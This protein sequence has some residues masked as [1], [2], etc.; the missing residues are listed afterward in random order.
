VRIAGLHID[1]FGIF[2][3]LDIAGFSPGL[4]VILGENES[5][6]TTL[7]AF[8]RTILF[9]FP[10]GQRRENIYP[11]LAGGRHGGHLTL[12]SG[13]GEEYVVSRYQGRNRGPV[14][15]TLPD[16]NQG[17]EEIVRQLTGAATEDLFRSIFAFSLEELERFDSLNKQAV[18]AAIYSAGAGVGKVSLAKVEKGLQDAIGKIFK[19]GGRNPIINILLRELQEIDLSIG[20]RVAEIE[21]Y[22]GLQAEIH[23]MATEVGSAKDSLDRKRRRLDRVR[24]LESGWEDWVSLCRIRE[25]IANLPK[26]EVFPTDGV[27]RLEKLQERERL[28][29]THRGEL[30]H[31]IEQVK[32][33]LHGFEERP[34]WLSVGEKIHL[35]ER[36]LERFSA[37]NVELTEIRPR[38]ENQRKALENDLKGLGPDWQMESLDQFDASVSARE[39][40]LRCQEALERTRDANREATRS[41]VRAT[42]SLEQAEVREREAEKAIGQIPEPKEKDPRVLLERRLGMRSLRNMIQAGRD[43]RRALEHLKER[44]DDLR[45]QKNGLSEQMEGIGTS[46]LWPVVVAVLL[47]AAPGAAAGWYRDLFAG[48]IV[49]AVGL[50]VS[51][52][53]LWFSLGQRKS[54]R[55]QKDLLKRQF[56]E[57]GEKLDSFGGEEARLLAEISANDQEIVRPAQ[58]FGLASQP[59]W[60]EVDQAEAVVET[61]QEALH[62]WQPTQQRYQECKEETERRQKELTEEEQRM[63]NTQKELQASEQHWQRWLSKAGLAES[64]SPNGALE[65]MERIRSLRQQAGS[66]RELE[67][68]LKVIEE[69]VQTYQ[70]EARSIAQ[71]LKVK[72]ARVQDVEPLVH[73][74]VVELKHEEKIQRSREDLQRQFAEYTAEREQN[75]VHL[76][77]VEKELNNLFREGG[78]TDEAEFRHRAHLYDRHTSEKEAL[79]QHLR[80][81]ENFGGRGE[82]QVR[83]QEQ[84]KRCSPERLQAERDELEQDVQ[85]LEKELASLQEQFG[86]LDERRQQLESA[87]ELSA[88]RQ[89]RNGLMAELKDAARRWSALTIC[90]GFFQKAR[91]IYEKERKQP[92]VRESEHFFRTI[93]DGR[94]QTIVAPHGEER[95]QIIGANGSRYD[96]D[97]LSR[98]TAEQLYLCLRFGYIE[99]FGR[100]ARPLP[101]V[102]DDILVNFDPQRARAA[103]RT[104]LGLAEKHQIIFFTCHPEAVSLIKELDQN[105]PVWQLEGG[106]CRL[107]DSHGETTS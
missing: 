25:E 37:A 3:E 83:F 103:I 43:L 90:L 7:L 76:R 34:E 2:H 74:M 24:L 54:L 61:E 56:F 107:D 104:M 12:L 94:Y 31:K 60:E 11:P 73:R 78:A 15:V 70:E 101:V 27:T 39:E 17:D 72:D 96:L 92:V 84:L 87:E 22:D 6:K 80:N 49:A 32:K 68:R 93:T 100:R 105:V 82:D 28:L 58:A 102:V 63:K 13:E 33:D 8:L 50:L 53:L 14:T 46:P 95:I 4:N 52:A 71:Q 19:P 51:V 41:F 69:L 67:A 42:S 57:I 20:Q 62:L 65:V 85:E 35:L 98:G 18:K 5:G 40:I 47:F 30:V 64:L 44:Q 77:Q 79:E 97:T 1:G 106:R 99:E 21:S 16:G 29:K 45:D 59:S 75:D 89:R 10:P 9:G 26:I 91:Q 36:G 48:A 81:L 38:L 55:L 23:Q 88:L 66:M 86:R